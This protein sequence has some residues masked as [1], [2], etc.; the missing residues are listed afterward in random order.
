MLD[1]RA[2]DAA[3]EYPTLLASAIHTIKDARMMPN[4]VVPDGLL[5]YSLASHCPP[6]DLSETRNVWGHV[7]ILLPGNS[8]MAVGQWV[9]QTLFIYE[10]SQV[11]ILLHSK[12]LMGR[13]I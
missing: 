6:M 12:C 8:N 7:S 3:N 2:A 9:L 10:M 5:R 1:M 11:N 4:P 13:P